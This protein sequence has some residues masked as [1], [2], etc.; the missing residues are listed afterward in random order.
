MYIEIYYQIFL[1]KSEVGGL[2][3]VLQFK[4]SILCFEM[5]GV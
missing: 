2:I 3:C 5:F 1:L 4:N